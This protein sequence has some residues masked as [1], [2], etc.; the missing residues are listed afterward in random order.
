MIKKLLWFPTNKCLINGDWTSPTKRVEINLFNP[1]NGEY[2]TS[3][4]RSSKTDVESA[5]SSACNA[6]EGNWGNKTA[7]ERG[8]I[9]LRMSRLVRKYGEK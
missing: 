7:L 6:L 8:R 2:L 1:S 9:L 5:V 4:A 3:I